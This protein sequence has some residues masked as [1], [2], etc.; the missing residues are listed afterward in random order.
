M[1]D[2]CT[3]AEERW[4]GVHQLIDHWLKERRDLVLCYYQLVDNPALTDYSAENARVLRKL[5]QILM[6]YVSAGHFEVYDQLAKEAEAF[7]DG[8]EQLLLELLPQIQASTDIALDFN[9]VFEDDA[10]IKEGWG[11][12]PRLL[13]RL[14]DTLITRFT[15]V[16]RLIET[17][18]TA[19][20]AH[21]SH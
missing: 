16:D 2:N 3:N 14:A 13:E 8:D 4:G 12:V 9:D 1:L 5:C 18:P 20:Q 17:L 21:L 10:L 6:D 19:P 7:G 11:G 15:L